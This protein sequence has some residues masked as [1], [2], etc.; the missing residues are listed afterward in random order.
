MKE[1]TPRFGWKERSPLLKVHENDLKL[2]LSEELIES[3]KGNGCKVF[4]SKEF[5]FL[6]LK[7]EVQPHALVISEKGSK[8][9]RQNPGFLSEVDFALQRLVESETEAFGLKSTF[10][11]PKG[12]K[13]EFIGRGS[14]SFVYRLNYGDLDLVVKIFN[15]AA[16]NDQKEVSQPYVNEMAQILEFNRKFG[17]EFAE[18]G[19][20]INE[21]LIA[22][23]L[24]TIS[25]FVE[26]SRVVSDPAV[27]H[28]RMYSL[29]LKFREFSDSGK[30]H[31]VFKNL[32]PDLVVF[33]YA[34]FKFDNAVVSSL[35][36]SLVVTD[37]LFYAD[38]MDELEEFEYELAIKNKRGA[39]WLDPEEIA[40][41]S[42]L[43]VAQSFE[44]YLEMWKFYSELSEVYA[45]FRVDLGK[46][47]DILIK[48]NVDSPGFGEEVCLKSFLKSRGLEFFLKSEFVG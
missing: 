20:S 12:S 7:G 42:K 36:Q 48:Y 13:F 43:T 30:G 31:A 21:P 17:K 45:D 34:R 29:F 2:G 18:I 23:G 8:V 25:P 11:S 35:D 4:R 32:F 1:I 26:R 46:I 19:V 6:N 14:Q 39:V 24:V 9:I 10:E 22:S 44:N 37:P 40:G 15:H 38:G 41:L 27:Q 3:V 33:E 28:A 16:N 5:G 47:E